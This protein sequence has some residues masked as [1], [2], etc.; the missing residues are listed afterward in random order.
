MKHL[1]LGGDGQVG[2]AVR[3]CCDSERIPYSSFDYA[4]FKDQDLRDIFNSEI[5]RFLY[6]CDFVHF[7]AF[8]VG[9]SRYLKK[10]QQSYEFMR[11]NMLIMLNTFEA[12][13]RTKKPFIFASSQMS[14][15]HDSAYGALKAVGEHY[16]RS[17]DGLFVKFWNVYDIETDLE[18]SHVITD[19]VLKARRGS[20]DVQSSGRETRQFLYGEDAAEALIKLSQEYKD[21]PRDIPLD[22]TSF[23]WSTIHE[24]AYIISKLYGNVPVN[25]GDTKDTQSL[26]NEPSAE[27]MQYWRPKTSLEN[28]IRKVKEYYDERY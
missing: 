20:I 18:K 3:N 17:L 4:R 21:I 28:G 2:T 1:I 27:I 14:N 11:N 6:D 24:V 8:D 16:T 13:K 25:F 7:L 15:M 23:R 10:H 26:R 22:V 9:G 5:Y 19:L 12:L